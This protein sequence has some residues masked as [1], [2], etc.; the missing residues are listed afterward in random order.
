MHNSGYY[1]TDSY[2]GL[3]LSFC[4]ATDAWIYRSYVCWLSGLYI[5]STIHSVELLLFTSH[6]TIRLLGLFV[7]GWRTTQNTLHCH[8]NNY[9]YKEWGGLLRSP[10][11]CLCMDFICVSTAWKVTA[12]MVRQEHEQ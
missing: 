3:G 4:I 11:P 8:N 9:Y 5:Y 7:G 12:C 1:V 2:L 6:R 10:T